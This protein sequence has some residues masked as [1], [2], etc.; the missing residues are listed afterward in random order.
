VQMIDPAII[1][2]CDMEQALRCIHV[3]LL[4]TQADSSLRPQMSTV[5]LMLSC[6]SVTLQNPTK[7]PFV[8][9]DG[10]QN[11]ESTCYGS[12]LSHASATTSSSSGSSASSQAAIVAPLSNADASITDL[13]P[14]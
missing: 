12:G 8:R 11:G 2:T 10:F 7:P 13:L 6:H 14:R 3:G 9:S 4:C 5:N 1:E